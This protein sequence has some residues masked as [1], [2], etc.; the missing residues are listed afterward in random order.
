MTDGVDL[1][2]AAVMQGLDL[3]PM[4]LDLGV[5]RGFKAKLNAHGMCVQESNLHIPYRK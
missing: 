5:T 3:G 4:G 1:G 2:V